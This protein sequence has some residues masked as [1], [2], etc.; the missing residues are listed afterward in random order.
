MNR[1]PY[2]VLGV[3]KNASAD[4]IRKAYRKLA[5]QYH[6]DLNPGNKEAE[7]KF[8]AIGDAHALLSDADKRARFD[9]GE[10]DASGQETPFGGARGYREYAEGAQGFRYGGGMGGGHG[11]NEEDLG[12]IFQD[13][14]SRQNGVFRGRSRGPAKGADHNYSLTI[15]FIDSINGS[16]SRITLPQGGTLD[17]KIP[18]GIENG[19]VLRLRGKG[20]AGHQGGPAGD[21][22]IT[23]SIEPSTVFT[24]DGRDVRMT[25]SV[26]LKT[27][28]LGG[29]IT[30]HT[31]SG[32]VNLNIPPHSD[33]GKVLRLRGRGV[34]AHG[35]YEDGN[36]YVTLQVVIGK[37]DKALEDF[38][39]DWNPA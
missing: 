18:P 20:A 26:D 37:I 39:T 34:K 6:P 28:I 36:L 4:V 38:L 35:S 7:E 1:D 27:A 31:P 12:D 17:V 25:Q 32:S 15:S 11:F 10:I 30:V 29:S 8:K 9:R 24:R 23:I 19:Q 22:L 16:T 33:T 3:K 5:K 2:E 13:L 14:F 21:A